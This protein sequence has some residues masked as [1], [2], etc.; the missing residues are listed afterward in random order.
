M[1]ESQ[2]IGESPYVSSY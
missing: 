1:F 2:K